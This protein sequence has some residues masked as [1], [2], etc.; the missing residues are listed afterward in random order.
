MLIISTVFFRQN[1]N[2]RIAGK[3]RQAF[4]TYVR[5]SYFFKLAK[6]THQGTKGDP[7]LK[8]PVIC[9]WPFWY[10][11]STGDFIIP[12]EPQPDREQSVG[13]NTDR[14]TIPSLHSRRRERLDQRHQE[15]HVGDGRRERQKKFQRIHVEW[16]VVGTNYRKTLLP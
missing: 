6:K 12:G 9:S 2:P 13:P 5:R 10:S 3:S 7:S 16:K 1:L 14:Q 4:H 8:T 11:S 15:G